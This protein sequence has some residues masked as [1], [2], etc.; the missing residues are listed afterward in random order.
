MMLVPPGAPLPNPGEYV[1]ARSDLTDQVYQVKVK[2]LISLR[3]NKQGDLIVEFTYS[4]KKLK[5]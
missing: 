1:E 5:G 2:K 4:H 3:W